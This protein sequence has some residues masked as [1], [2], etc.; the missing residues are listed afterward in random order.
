MKNEKA[1][2][3]ELCDYIVDATQTPEKVMKDVLEIIKKE[4]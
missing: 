4:S 3:S 2:A 1:K